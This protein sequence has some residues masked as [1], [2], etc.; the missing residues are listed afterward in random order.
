MPRQKVLKL[1][2]EIRGDSECR[3][4]KQSEAR[5][6]N[7]AGRGQ[8]GLRPIRGD[9]YFFFNLRR[10]SGQNSLTTRVR[11]SYAIWVPHTLAVLENVR[12]SLGW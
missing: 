6:Y 2:N 8:C 9:T 3:S 11:V 4:P 1:R 12:S 7:A 10:M 5:L